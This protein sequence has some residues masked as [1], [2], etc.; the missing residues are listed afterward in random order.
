MPIIFV[1]NKSTFFKVLKLL[2][3]TSLE[4]II[5]YITLGFYS[6]KISKYNFKS[7]NLK[8]MLKTPTILNNLTKKNWVTE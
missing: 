3:R 2:R 4:I 7:L 8:S 6:Q 5:K 1:S